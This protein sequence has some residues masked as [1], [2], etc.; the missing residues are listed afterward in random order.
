MLGLRTIRDGER[1][2]IWDKGGS[3]NFVQGP[4][5]VITYGKTVQMLARFAAGAH[6][7]LVVQ[8]KDGRSQHLHGPAAVW[9]HP[10][11]H[12][13]IKVAPAIHVDANEAIVVYRQEK[14]RV[15]R[16]VVRGPD[17][18]MPTADEWLHQF[19]WHG[20]DPANPDRKIPGALN[21]V[22][23]RVIP[24]QMYVDV[25]DV[26]TADDALLV[27]QLMVFFELMDVGTMLD[28][29]HDVVADFYNAVTADIIH[30]VAGLTFEAFKEHTEKL[31]DLEIYGALT[32]RASRIGYRINKVVYRGY[33]ANP[34]LQTMHDNAIEARTKLRLEAETEKQAQELLDLRLGREAD[35]AHQRQ[36]MEAADM[37]HQM[38]LKGGAF[39]EALRQKR[40]EQE[41]EVEASRVR[42]EEA[43]RHKRLE[44]EQTLAAERTSQEMKV[45][46]QQAMN[47]ERVTF[48]A[49][50]HG[51]QVDVTRFLTA[52]YP[53]A[54]RL[55]R[56]EGGRQPRLHLHQES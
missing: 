23:L 8:F 42:S 44:K 2:A 50:L 56:I 53:A 30:F 11:E 38:R 4:R 14:E 52:R 37:T 10:V 48:L 22:K 34:K 54:E 1:A 43:L 6:E 9:F 41:R 12:Q 3:I 17:V 15:T 18:F 49:S 5:R 19:R 27:I 33:V 35:R 32:S 31:N 21:F 26:R 7:Y 40:V 46:H 28:Q 45:A 13:S 24:D 51:M 55:I 39:D 25:E 20:A 36:E 47:R 29:T 16:R